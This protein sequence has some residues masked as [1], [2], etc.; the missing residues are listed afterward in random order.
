MNVARPLSGIKP[1]VTTSIM[2]SATSATTLL[3]IFR[4]SV[5]ETS[6]SAVGVWALLQ[7]LFIVT[8]VAGTG[9]GANITR[10]VAVVTRHKGT[11]QLRP[12]LQASLLLGTVPVVA[13]SLICFLPIVGFV[14]RRYADVVS[15]QE[16]AL[17]GLACVFS[18]I[19]STLALTLLAICE[20]AGNLSVVN[21]VV[22]TSYVFGLGTIY[23]AL[24][25]FDVVGI[26]V[27]YVVMA[28]TQFVLA[29]ILVVRYKRRLCVA[30]SCTTTRDVL[31]QL[32][33]ES[34]QLTTVGMLRL[35]FEPVTKLVLSFVGGLPALAVFDLALRIATQ[36][37]V[38]VQAG[39]QPLLVYA[40]RAGT[41]ERAEISRTFGLGQSFVSRL[42]IMTFTV[43][44]VAAPAL[45]VV[46]L[47]RLE[48]TFTLYFGVLAFGNALNSLGLMGYFFQL[49][50]GALRPLLQIHFHMAM[51]NLSA[52]LL[53]GYLFNGTGVV[54]GYA[55]TLGYGGL[56]AS[57][58]LPRQ[59]RQSSGRSELRNHTPWLLA[60]GGAIFW[61]L[62]IGISPPVASTTLWISI[63]LTIVTTALVA[64]SVCRAFKGL[65][66]S[67]LAPPESGTS[68]RSDV[69]E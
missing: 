62:L 35:S 24:L 40:A 18:G 29:A 66:P 54:V 14:T 32:R 39:S 34:T 67:L 55:M 21:L 69:P 19:L 17:L 37:R 16:I 7:G 2:A 61:L 65:N 60:G 9:L 1:Q 26:G 11:L 25:V 53:L 68:S 3:V 28:V 50:S 13:L 57:R 41:A 36:M 43:A 48:K 8:R 12:L 31:H 56:C 45:S 64:R 51:I 6:V 20:G 47:G 27:T 4:L 5:E 10:H 23:P 63:L 30:E 42:A 38:L 52:G 22:I 33:V 58:L 44:L 49:S 46:G 15:S 59:A